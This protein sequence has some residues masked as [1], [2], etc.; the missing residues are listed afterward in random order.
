MSI[1]RFVYI[2][3]VSQILRHADEKIVSTV[4]DAAEA[5]QRRDGRQNWRKLFTTKETEHD[6]IH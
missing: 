2:C 6:R 1:Y 5:T 3:R 4:Y